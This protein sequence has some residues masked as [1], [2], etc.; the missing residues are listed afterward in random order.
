MAAAPELVY[1]QAI[2]LF[3]A[4]LGKV[5]TLAFA[6]GIVAAKN[7][8]ILPIPID[9]HMNHS[10]INNI[11]HVNG[12]AG[13][14][15]GVNHSLVGSGAVS[16]QVVYD[17]ANTPDTAGEFDIKD[18]DTIRLNEETLATSILIIEARWL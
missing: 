17:A 9:L 5:S 16:Q 15:L 1:A 7:D 13:S 18:K 8:I 14:W 6:P 4:N 10:P 2:A 11:L 3:K 12:A